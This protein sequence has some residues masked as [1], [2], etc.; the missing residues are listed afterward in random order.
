MTPLLSEP[1]TLVVDASVVLKWVL[2]EDG[3]PAALRLLERYQDGQTT[4]LAPRLLLSEAANVL[5]KYVHRGLLTAPQATAAYDHFLVNAPRLADSSR[6][7]AAALQLSL[8]HRRTAY[9]CLYLAL[10]LDRQCDLVTADE[11]F[12]LAVHQ[13]F[14]FVQLLV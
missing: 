12:F 6:V 8:A 4:L 5:W 3:R 9:D 2:H 7:W 14:P 11:E 10:A 13:A 1:T